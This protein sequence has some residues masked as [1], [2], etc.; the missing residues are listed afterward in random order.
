MRVKHQ[1]SATGGT[2]QNVLN[3]WPGI[4]PSAHITTASKQPQSYKVPAASGLRLHVNTVSNLQQTALS[5]AQII[6][7]LGQTQS[8]TLNQTLV[9]THRSTHQLPPAP[10]GC[11]LETSAVRSRQ[12]TY[13]Q[14]CRQPQQ[15]KCEG[16]GTQEG[17]WKD[18]AM[19]SM[20]LCQ[21]LFVSLRTISAQCK[22]TA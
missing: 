15:T 12:R 22:L 9:Q 10:R 18:K 11:H 20:R 3:T 16:K 21:G 13:L 14:E 2:S 17:L 6:V 1:Q 4:Q 5:S 7:T 19:Q 8:E